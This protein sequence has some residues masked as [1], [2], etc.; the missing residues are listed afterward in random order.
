MK[1]LMFLAMMVLT[2]CGTLK[3]MMNKGEVHKK[4]AARLDANAYDMNLISLKEKLTASFAGE[5]ESPTIYLPMEMSPNSRS[6]EQEHEARVAIE[7]ALD[8][9]GFAYKKTLYKN[10]IDMDF[11]AMFKDRKKELEKIKANL[12]TGPFHVIED[13]KTH[14]IIVKGINVFKGELIGKDKSRLTVSQ[15]KNLERDPMQLSVNWF[16]SFKDQKLWF[17]IDKG[18]I[19]MEK[20]MKSAKRDKMTEL[21]LLHYLDPQKFV[22]WEKESL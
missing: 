4:M 16:E 11:M 18:P 12:K 14:F 22:S 10:E 17:S 20:S 1:F 19:S 13:T 8:D 9:E 15:L 5:H 21:S 7:D 2:S 3:E 6:M